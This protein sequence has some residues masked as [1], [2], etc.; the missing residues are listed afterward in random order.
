MMSRYGI[1]GLIM[2][3]SAPSLTSRRCRVVEKRRI[4]MWTID[5]RLPEERVPFHRVEAGSTSCYRTRGHSQRP[6]WNR[7]SGNQFESRR[8]DCVPERAIQAARKFGG[9]AHERASIPITCVDEFSF[10]GQNPSVHHV[11][12]GNAIRAGFGIGKSH[13]SETVD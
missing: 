3:I 13:V 5:S 2:M 6:P 11:A 12:R 10:D 4:G 8:G 9:I 1:P 7:P